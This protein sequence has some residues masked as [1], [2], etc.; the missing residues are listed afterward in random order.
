MGKRVAASGRAGSETGAGRN[1]Q[2]PSPAANALC[3]AHQIALFVGV[4]VLGGRLEWMPGGR[5]LPRALLSR[6]PMG[7][8]QLSGGQ[9]CS[10]HWVRLLLSPVWFLCNRAVQP[11]ERGSETELPGGCTTQ[12]NLPLL[13]K[14]A[15][16][17]T[18]LEKFQIRCKNV[19]LHSVLAPFPPSRVGRSGLGNLSDLATI[20]PK[21]ARQWARDPK[22]PPPHT[23]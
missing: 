10:W 21:H 15:R 7:Q 14:T 18:K 19:A 2:K 16:E 1:G 5:L 8:T 13:A 11:L 6:A 17:G 22:P 4:L 23:S 9:P 3:F 20:P 12:G